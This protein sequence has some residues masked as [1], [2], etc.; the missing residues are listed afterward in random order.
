MIE[1]KEY[2]EQLF[3]WKDEDVIKVITGIRRSGKSTLLEQFQQCLLND[4]VD[5]SQI[6]SI[7]FEKLEYEHLLNYKSLYEYIKD[8]LIEGKT[9]YVLL[10]EIQQVQSFEKVVD[11]LYVQK[12]VDLYIT[13]SNAYTLS[14][15]LATL[16]TGRYIEISILPLSF[17]EYKS[18]SSG[19][20][21]E[22]VFADYMKCG[23]FPYISTMKDRT[24]D[25]VDSYIEGIYNT[26]LIRD[27][28]ERQ[29]RKVLKG[30]RRK[31][32]DIVLLK[33]IARYLSS[34]I[35]N[36]ISI[37]SITDYL[38]SSG[39]KVSYNTVDDYVYSLIEAFIFHP[40]ERFDIVGKQ[41]LK[42][43]QKLYIVDLALRNHI[44]PRR[45][46][47]F[48]FSLENIVYF[49]L[50]RRGYKVY[51]GRI[52]EFEVDFVALKSG[53]ITYYQVS[54]S[55]TDKN[56]FDREM[57]PLTIIRDNYR[58]IILTMDRFTVGNYGGIEVINILDW[59]LS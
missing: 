12:G 42:N 1:R 24:N 40:V 38:T 34:V 6:I 2:L 59:L 10:D 54:A 44:L 26:I 7:N 37:K 13:G 45:E 35:G 14:G 19:M 30:G 4:G 18:F 49:E 25:K 3:S 43:N 47:D 11:G 32:L 22:E 16:L 28:E 46:Y 31:V 27:I 58:K 9:T 57:R 53:V 36:T 52:R 55:L 41:I 50:L 17:K 23:G 5:S 39:R 21:E 48:G 51:I 20:S 8:R 56:T 15:D 33:T 29:S